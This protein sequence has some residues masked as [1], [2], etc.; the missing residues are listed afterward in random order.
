MNFLKA[1]II[2]A[3][4]LSTVSSTYAREI[5][6]EA[7][8]FGLEGVLKNREKDLYGVINGIDYEEWNPSK[9]TFLPAYYSSRDISGKAVC[10]RELIKAL[11]KQSGAEK[12]PVI[13]II[14]RLSEQKGMD[15]VIQS[16]QQLF[17]YDIRLVILGRVMNRYTR[18]C[19][20][21][22]ANTRESSR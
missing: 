18:L 14:G 5:L 16:A 3:D 19:R 22:P 7:Y 20:I 12:M 13:G 2:S 9:D 10:K 4:I 21:W 11:F 8:G 17:S 15:L 1:G 6:T